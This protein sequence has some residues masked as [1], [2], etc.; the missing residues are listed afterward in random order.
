MKTNNFQVNKSVLNFIH[1]RDYFQNNDAES[2]RLAISNAI[3]FQPRQYGRELVDFNMIAPDDNMV[4]GGLLGDYVKLDE[5]NSGTFRYPWN[6]LIHFESFEDLSE[7]R[8]AVAL[9]DN[10]FTT[11]SHVSG[12]KTALTAHEF[13]YANLN[14]W[15]VETVITLRQNDAIFYRPW[16]FHS[17]EEKL[18]L[19]FHIIGD[20]D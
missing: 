3:H 17:F 19:C 12:A 1:A 7:W 5:K 20:E 2:Y 16:V 8:L 14:D 6:N 11:Y 10:V 4:F 9:E 18:L 13:D 15:V